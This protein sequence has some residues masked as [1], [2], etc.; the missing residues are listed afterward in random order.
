MARSTFYY[1]QRR[2]NHPDKH[3]LL[4]EKIITIYHKN[5]G[6]YGYRRIVLELHNQGVFVNHKTVE[7]LMQQSGF[8]SLVRVKKYRS[9]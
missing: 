6:R 4:R 1:H 3:A 5:K 7:K 2:L 8:K 9:Y